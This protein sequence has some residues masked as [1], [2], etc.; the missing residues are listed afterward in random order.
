MTRKA[1]L[2][3]A[4]AAVGTMVAATTGSAAGDKA[5]PKLA[6]AHFAQLGGGT[7]RGLVVATHSPGARRVRVHVSL[8][9][10]PPTGE[11]LGG[12][13]VY[14]V[15]ADKRRCS[16]DYDADGDVDGA[17]YLVW[18]TPSIIMANTEGDMHVRSTG[19]RASLRSA[20]SIRVLG[21]GSGGKVTQRACGAPQRW[22]TFPSD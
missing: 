11:A 5:T 17:D 21:R 13:E 12:P 10:R 6:E 4:A 14:R 18:R 9:G 2:G 7:L 1:K 15:V 16:A 19:L 8:H 20:K 22:A 3:L